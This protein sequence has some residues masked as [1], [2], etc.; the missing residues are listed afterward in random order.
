MSDDGKSEKLEEMLREQQAEARKLREWVATIVSRDNFDTAA[1]ALDA[2]IVSLR[3]RGCDRDSFVVA[4][5]LAVVG[6]DLS[7]D[8]SP[9]R[10]VALLRKFAVCGEYVIAKRRLEAEREVSLRGGAKA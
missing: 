2:V 7:D 1:D 10:F 6:I 5:L 8:I 4:A 9:D 3:E